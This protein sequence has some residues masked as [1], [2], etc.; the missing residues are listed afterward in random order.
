MGF[1][2]KYGSLSTVDTAKEAL[3]DIDRELDDQTKAWLA[4]P[5]DANLP[6]VE[7]YKLIRLH[8]MIGGLQ[9]VLWLNNAVDPPTKLPK[10]FDWSTHKMYR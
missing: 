2:D 10:V 6:N 4:N 3:L 7:K 5:F 8:K 1:C 9:M